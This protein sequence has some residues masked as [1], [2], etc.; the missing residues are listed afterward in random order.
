LKQNGEVATQK[1]FDMS[2]NSTGL[3]CHGLAELPPWTHWLTSLTSPPQTMGAARCSS[4]RL[5]QPLSRC[6][7]ILSYRD[8]SL[9]EESVCSS[10]WPSLRDSWRILKSRV[11]SLGTRL[12]TRPS[13]YILTGTMDEQPFYLQFVDDV[14]P[15]SVFLYTSILV[16]LAKRRL[17]R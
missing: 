5:L 10:Y 12:R 9:E 14:S 15:C 4:V 7:S 2:L 1:S 11:A 8:S 17:H 16:R 13:Q 6:F 3:P